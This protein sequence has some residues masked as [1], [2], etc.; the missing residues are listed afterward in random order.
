MS[1]LK[2]LMLSVILVTGHW[3]LVTADAATARPSVIGTAAARLP[4]MTGRITGTTTTTTGTNPLLADAECIE[5]YTT[6]LRG[7]DACGGEFEE[8]TNK[9]LFFAKRPLCASTLIQCSTNGISALFGTSAQTSFANKN[10]DGTYVYPT[11]GSV[12]GQLIGAAHVNNRYDTSQC[13]RRYTDCL[14]KDDV[15]GADFELCTSNTEFKT[16]KLFCESTLARCQDEGK[17][18]LFG[19][20]NTAANPSASSRL[21]IMIS[22]GG[23]LAAV[24]AVATCYKVADQCIL[25]ACSQ[26][27][28]KC[29]EGSLHTLVDAAENTFIEDPNIAGVSYMDDLGAINRN[30][31]FGHIEKACLDVIGGN[32]FCYATFIGDGRMPT[33]SQLRDEDNKDS[34]FATAYSER[35]KNSLKSKIDDLIENFDKKTKARCADTITQCAMRNCGGGI[36]SA[37]YASAFKPANTVKGVTNPN[38]RTSIEEGCEAV[39]NADTACKYAAAT[40]DMTT[41]ILDFEDDSIFDKLFT[42]ADDKDVTNPDPI[43]VVG[44]LNAR[45]ST[46]YNQ[47][48][49]DLMKRQCTTV[50]T[51]CVRTMCG[52]DFENCYR[53][54]TD[55]YSTLTNTGTA[56]FDRS[57]NRVGGVLDYTVILGLCLNTVKSNPVCE[58][59][60]MAEAAKREINSDGADSWGAGAAGT[61]TRNAWLGAGVYSAA[62]T[63]Y[64]IQDEDADGNLLC[65]T[66]EDNGGD[67]G[68][69]DD[70]SG[71]FIYPYMISENSYKISQSTNTVF[72]DLV[73]DLE[74]EAQALYNA[75]LTKQQNMCLSGASGIMGGRDISGTF[76]WAKLRNNKVPKSYA[77]DGL[78]ENQFVA[79]NELYGS[80]CR[81]RITLQSDDKAIQ[82][83]IRSGSGWSTAYFAAGDAFTCGSWIPQSELEKISDAVA[84]EKSGTTAGGALKSGQGWAVT[85]LTVL[86]AIGGTTAMEA[87]TDG[88]GFA[89]LFNKR[90]DNT[91][92][93]N[94][95]IVTCQ[96]TY[97]TAIDTLF[98]ATTGRFVDG[99]IIGQKALTREA[100]GPSGTGIIYYLVTEPG[101]ELTQATVDDYKNR[102]ESDRTRIC[103]TTTD[104][105]PGNTTSRVLADVLGAGIGA[106]ALGVGSAQIIKANNR[107]QFNAAQTEWMNNI[108]N[109]IRCYIGS[110]EVGSYG[111]MISTEME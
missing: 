39:V 35:M 89:G 103:G 59:H 66:A 53:N 104:K 74:K 45:L 111:D 29:K 93:N 24:N 46:S 11:D 72:R 71:L 18:E 92:Q 82:E 101:A 91:T 15:C 85:G 8:C 84:R 40:F 32:K 108:G 13:V 67:I 26:N 87:L 109:H 38:T 12:L 90:F 19:T 58:E 99:K 22:E 63:G 48:S 3:S 16:Q 81:I 52:T 49:L 28:Y 1:L 30:E 110:E 61:T 57:M 4:T 33:N 6:C 36:G 20:A 102:M 43:G 78:K 34:I 69:C 5:S 2:K 75:K 79:S 86:G 83:A 77:V 25:N 54:R 98:N 7:G 14:K 105:T 56:A 64:T 80:F 65:T 31:I 76:Q 96:N 37:C 50:A 100:S 94:A 27:P 17:T 70:V 97:R 55:V 23:D 95:A 62:D 106:T 107:A 51:G 10:S 68:R 44:A 60:I 9:E 47:A 21:G 41:G 88:K 42:S 73:Y